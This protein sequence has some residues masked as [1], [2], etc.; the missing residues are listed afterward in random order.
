MAG[1]VPVQLSVTHFRIVTYSIVYPDE[2]A[3]GFLS[4]TA[5]NISKNNSCIDIRP[6]AY[7]CFYTQELKVLQGLEHINLTTENSKLRENIEL[8]VWF[9]YD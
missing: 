1:R 2:S 7:T 4:S 9:E 8:P 6:F 3:M 5:S